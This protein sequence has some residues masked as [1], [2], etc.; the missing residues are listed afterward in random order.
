MNLKNINTLALAL[1]SGAALTAQTYVVLVKPEGSKEWG[2]IKT[3]GEYAI[4]PQFRG[5]ESFSENGWAAVENPKT[6]EEQFININGE[7]MT[8]EAKDLKLKP[9]SEGLAPVRKD[10]M[11][12]YLDESGKMK[13]A[14]QYDDASY[15]DNGHAVVRQGDTYMVIDSEG[16]TVTPP[17]PVLK[18]KD[19]HSG[20]IPFYTAEKKEG[21]VNTKGEIAIAAQYDRVGYFNGDLAWARNNNDKIGYLNKAGAW[22][23]EPQ[24]DAVKDFPEGEPLARVKLNDNWTYVNRSGEI[25]NLNVEDQND[26]SNGVAYGKKGDLVGFYDASGTWVIQPQFD[27]VR[28]FKNGYAAARK[29]DL[30]GLIDKTG[31]WVLEPQFDGI[32]DVE[33]VK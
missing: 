22:V 9:F 5:A 10:K 25:V 6:K 21:F 24:F 16:N 15:F 28:D 20:M 3:D 17:A 8:I 7:Y 2:Y 18:M 1:I 26:F 4:K 30:W 23:I 11:W 31:A 33:K 29:G 13:I 27:A 19:I 14:A 32:K 12:G